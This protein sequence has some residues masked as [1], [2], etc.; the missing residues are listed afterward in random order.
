MRQILILNSFFFIIPFL[1]REM[2]FCKLQHCFLDKIFGVLIFFLS[3]VEPSN[4]R[5]KLSRKKWIE[6]V[7][8]KTLNT[9]LCLSKINL[10]YY[11]LYEIIIS[12]ATVVLTKNLIRRHNFISIDLVINSR[13]DIIYALPLRLLAKIIR[14]LFRKSTNEPKA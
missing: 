9:I 2:S 3:N 6:L 10:I 11:S 5:R 8:Y 1:H 4:L 13:R 12:F 14:V 7:I